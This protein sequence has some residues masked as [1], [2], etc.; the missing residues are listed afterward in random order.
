MPRKLESSMKFGITPTV[1][2]GSGVHHQVYLY[3]RRG[4]PQG[5]GLKVCRKGQIS[6]ETIR[7][8]L[9][10]FEQIQPPTVD[11]APPRGTPSQEE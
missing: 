4:N 2:R 6:D 1:E 3:G 11:Q 10:D 8:T 7:N 9:D 5:S